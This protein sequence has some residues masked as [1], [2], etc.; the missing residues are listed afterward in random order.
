[1]LIYSNAIKVSP[2]PTEENQPMQS[3]TEI[4]EKASSTAR[5]SS[6]RLRTRN[7]LKIAFILDH[8]FSIGLKSGL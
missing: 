8:I 4:F 2:S 1:M 7:F 5:G 3:E 6:D